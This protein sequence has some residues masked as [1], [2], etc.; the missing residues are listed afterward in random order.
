MN[1]LI[2]IELLER[3]ADVKQI[4]IDQLMLVL[5]TGTVVVYHRYLRDFD[6]SLKIK[7]NGCIFEDGRIASDFER[8]ELVDFWMH[9]TAEAF[10]RD[11]QE[12]S[13]KMKAVREEVLAL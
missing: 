9:A 10:N 7:V 1:S 13:E 5:S 4:D 12:R 6:L 8:D 3:A 2:N 11:E